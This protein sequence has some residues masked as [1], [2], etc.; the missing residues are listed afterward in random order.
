MQA[1]KSL[2][3]NF[4]NDEDVV[5]KIIEAGELSKK[6]KILEIGP[7]R[8]FLTRE[9]VKNSAEVLAVEKDE[10]L[11][12][13]C[14]N[15]LPQKNLDIL[16]GDV[17]K[18]NWKEILTNRGFLGISSLSKVRGKTEQRTEFTEL[19]NGETRGNFD[20]KICQTRN[21]YKLIANIPYYI[22]GK[23]LRL[24]LENDFKPQIL[25]LMIQK[26]VAE[27]ICQ[28]PGKHSVLS[29]SVQ[30][31]GEP[32]IIQTVPREKFEPVPEVDSAILKIKLNRKKGSS[33]DLEKKFFRLVKIGFSS[34]RKTFLN[35]LSAGL[36]IE[37]QKIEEKLKQFGFDKN[38]RAQE[39]R[40]EDWGKM[41]S[42]GDFI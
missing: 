25:V 20:E 22:T 17:L 19:V 40:I 21:S 6:D 30:Y 2:G 12:K 34:P 8:G 28:K 3:Q 27:R 1:K 38:T 37:K 18:L 4:L 7:G 15:N 9:L 41:V 33:L 35:N 13:Y 14:R 5:E 42:A 26:E 39:L 10:E 24:F 31:F 11:V 16:E 23:I 29:L 36:K 32:E